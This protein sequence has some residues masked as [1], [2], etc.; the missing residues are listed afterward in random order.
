MLTLGRFFASMNYK[1]TSDAVWADTTVDLP[2]ADFVRNQRVELVDVLT[3]TMHSFNVDK[4][5]TLTL[6]L[7]RILH[8]LPYAV[9]ELTRNRDVVP[10]PPAERN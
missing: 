6:P 9:L 7:Q 3:Q 10:N 4:S 5:G 2:A 8:S 1:Q